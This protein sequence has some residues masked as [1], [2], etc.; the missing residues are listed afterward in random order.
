MCTFKTSIRRDRMASISFNK[1]GTV[2]HA[3][4]YILGMALCGDPRLNIVVENAFEIIFSDEIEVFKNMLYFIEHTN[5][6]LFKK[7]YDML[8]ERKELLKNEIDRYTL[9]L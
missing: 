9:K 7:G 3:Y 5:P 8:E 6:K 4:T 2:D 1:D